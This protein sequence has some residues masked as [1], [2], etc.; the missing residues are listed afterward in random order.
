MISLIR[1]LP[2]LGR[3]VSMCRAV[4]FRS[5]RVVS[6]ILRAV[7]RILVCEGYVASVVTRLGSWRM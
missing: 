1:A 5:A 6:E 4:K 2:V 7:D 3:E